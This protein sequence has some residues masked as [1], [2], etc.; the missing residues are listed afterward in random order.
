MHF[1]KIMADFSS[2]ILK[3]KFALFWNLCK[4]WTDIGCYLKD[5]NCA[6]CVPFFHSIWAELL[7]SWGVDSGQ[8][9]CEFWTSLVNLPSHG[10]F[11]A[12]LRSL[13]GFRKCVGRKSHQSF[14]Q[15]FE[16]IC[17]NQHYEL[18]D[19]SYFRRFWK[20]FSRRF[21]SILTVIFM[22][23]FRSTWIDPP[24]TWLEK[25]YGLF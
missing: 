18:R 23:C 5:K 1:R 25:K 22:Q 20:W 24:I 2:D 21:R 4:L 19:S 13:S 6:Y 17:L 12:K 16:E 14:F 11:M 10:R 3:R 15:K 8:C 9:V 7:I